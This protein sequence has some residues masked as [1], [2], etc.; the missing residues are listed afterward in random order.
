VNVLVLIHSP[1]RMWT[2]PAEH[3]GQ[4]R[5]T[6]PQHTFL[7]AHDDAEGEQLIRDADVAFSSQIGPAHLRAAPRLRWIHSPSAGVGSMLYPEMVASSIAITNGRGM[8]A[9]TIAEH[10]VAVTLA[11][12]RRL[13]LAFARQAERVWAQD[14]IGAW[15]GNRTI[16]GSG[17]LIIG[18]GAIGSAAAA[19][20][21]ALGAVVTGI[22]RR[23]GLPPPA[24]ISRVH[25][26]EDLHTL[27]PAADLVLIA[28]PQT[29]ETRGL[30]GEEE[31]QLMKR[32][33]MLVNVSRGGLVDEAA[34][35][36]ALEGGRLAGAALDVFRH[37]PLEPNHPLWRVPNLL[38]TPH[39]SG[40]RRDHWDAAVAL[41][42]DNLRRFER[43]SDLINV[44]DKGAGY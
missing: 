16:A 37:E 35:A 9:D 11:L 33:A 36:A 30:I 27:L 41:F 6:F 28:A 21:H 13:P 44:V 40:F 14:E 26:P 29:R 25:P 38:I 4:L 15:P 10:V 34:L 31:L 12:M 17:V 5:R 18:L 39:T 42:S 20:L 1:F 19:R 3:V 22:R 7:H 23:R 8:S 2:I 24:G 43:G 32:D